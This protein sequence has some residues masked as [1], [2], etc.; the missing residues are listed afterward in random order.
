MSTN[1]APRRG[2]K[3]KLRKGRLV[4]TVSVVAGV[5]YLVQSTSQP[6]VG[7]S[8]AGDFNASVKVTITDEDTN[9]TKTLDIVCEPSV[10]AAPNDQK[11]D[12]PAETEE[13]I[14][15]GIV[16]PAIYSI[17][18]SEELQRYTYDK[19]VEYN[20]GN[21]YELVL[22]MMWQE[23]NFTPDTI[24][25][26][27]DYG[28]M[29][30]NSCNHDWLGTTLGITDF[31]DAKQCI[32]AGTYL[33]SNLLLKYEDES[34]ALMAYNL[35]EGGASKYWNNGNYSSTYSRGVLSKRSAI[36]SNNYPVISEF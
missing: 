13:A 26:T 33:I 12:A 29:Q 28:I 9:E 19:C 21:Y 4:L 34:K 16:V 20:I 14:D 24:S 18:L 2:N 11:P 23:S 25:S 31:L 36:E 35:G 7:D 10:T 6:I 17:P 22:A 27:N 5:V 32:D 15:E 1:T 3:R 8:F 30:I